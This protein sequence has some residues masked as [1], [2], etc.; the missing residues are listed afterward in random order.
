MP[1]NSEKKTLKRR[2][3]LGKGLGALLGDSKKTETAPTSEPVDAVN[4]NIVEKLDEISID[5]IERNPFQPR[6]EFKDEA[7]KE[8]ADS[9]RVQGIIQPITV[10]RLTENQFQIISGE[11]RWRASKMAGLEK[12]PAYIRG[13]NDAQML[14]MALIE[15]IQREDLNPI[16]VAI[17]YQRLIAE[18]DLKQEELGDRVGKK[19]STVANYLRLLK[20]PPEIQTGL[21]NGM[22]SMG[23]ARA[24]VNVNSIEVQLAL[25]DTI[26]KDELSVRKTENLVRDI[27]QGKD[28]LTTKSKNKNEPLDFEFSR[29]Q[30]DLS[31]H[32][33]TQIKI[34]N[35]D[36]GKGEIKIPYQSVEDLNRILDILKTH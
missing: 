31:S 13:A 5:H 7:L 9:I 29:L 25:F 20:L 6:L 22:I 3:A 8:L 10:R 14:E 33:G 23:H 24:L 27:I 12:I 30:R 32:F 2:N 15:N 26:V 17:S 34:K 16:E 1:D 28:P 18:C 35:S 36:E 4:V 21:R 19:R 11:R